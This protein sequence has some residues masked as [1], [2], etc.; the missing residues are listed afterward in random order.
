MQKISSIT[1]SP[2]SK[3]MAVATADRVVHLF[4]ENGQRQDKFSTRP[5]DKDNKSYIVRAM[6]F[7]PD[8]QKLAIAQ[9]DNIVFIYKLGMEWGEKKSICNK[10][11]Q[12]SSVTCMTWPN[13]R[14]GDLI[15]GTAEGKI[16]QGVLKSNKS[17]SIYGSD[18]FVVS[19]SSSPNGQWVCSGHLDGTILTFN[20]DT[21]AKSKIQHSTVPYA[22]AWGSHILAGGN[23]G[24][25]HF[26]E[27]TGDCFQRFDY[28]KDERVKEFTSAAFNATGETAI[29][30]NFNRF[31]V[32][33]F[34]SKRPQWD[35]ICC[36]QIENYYSVTSVAW[37]SD[38]SKI[39]IGSLCGSVDVFDVCLKKQKYKGKFEFTYVSLSQV[40][41]KRIENSQRI[42]LKSAQGHEISKINVYQDRYLVASTSS[43]LLLGDMETC[44]LSEIPWRGSGNEKYDFSNPNI[45]MVFNAG[46]LFIVEYG[47]NEV[48]GTCRTENVHPNMISARLNYA[49]QEL[50]GGQPT[51]I[52]AYLLDTMTLCIQDLRTNQ[53]LANIA[54]DSKIDYLELNP[55]GSKLLFRDKR[56]QLHLYNIKEQKKQTLLNYCKYVSWVPNSDV[57]V[58][59]N[60]NNLCVWYS[61]DEP[62]KVTMYEVKGDVESIQRT[63]G[64]TEVIVDTGAST[65][66]YELKEILIEFG[67]ALEYK[68]LEKAVQILEPLE[69]TPEIEA[70]WNT[71]AK[72]AMEQQN[73][74]VA[75]R[76]Y[77][78]L[79]NI[80]KA[81]YLRKINKLVASEG[82]E[83]FR[84]QAK[85]AVFDKQFHRAEA[86]LL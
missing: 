3:R 72:L 73:L 31:Y 32:Y 18:S 26:Y 75:E 33:N 70:N 38:G 6:A 54:H 10:F 21:K 15:I 42:V 19:I 14:H 57:V 55:A 61:I 66:S 69:M 22:L 63:E 23:D 86:I 40:I 84:V 47:V 39:G 5:A 44:K 56:R 8:N 17:Q 83:N 67:A 34:N 4:D 59:Q 13:E 74:Y 71:L 77:A 45:C 53:M 49:E 60:R 85:L 82:L 80:S 46:E 76:C 52:I 81:D 35:E 36:K 79:G 48:T 41:V 28:S 16:K 2:N 1:W 30:G 9:S 51:K 25:V 20:I 78:A 27:Q 29:V 58:A 50:R 37:K 43:T 24:K 62:D 12:N 11:A 7:S 65:I 68:G 64:K